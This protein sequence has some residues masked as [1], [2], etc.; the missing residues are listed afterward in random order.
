MGEPNC[1][2]LASHS[3]PWDDFGLKDEEH[4]VLI[5]VWYDH[6]AHRRSGP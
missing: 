1:V 5:R 2:K 4:Q 6:M 3:G